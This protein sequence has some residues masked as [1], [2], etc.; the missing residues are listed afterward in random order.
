[1]DKPDISLQQ[2]YTKYVEAHVKH[3]ESKKEES[4]LISKYFDTKKKDVML[5]RICI[6]INLM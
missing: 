2:L 1:M 5:N 3:T 6:M 4:K